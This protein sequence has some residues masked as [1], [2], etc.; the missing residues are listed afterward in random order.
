MPHLT[1]II[2]GGVFVMII[3]VTMIA[4]TIFRG[5]E[6]AH[7]ESLVDSANLSQT[8]ADNFNGMIREIDLGLLTI[9]DEANR[10]KKQSQ[11]DSEEIKLS[12]AKQ[13]ERHPGSLC[14]RI[15]GADGKL[16]VGLKNIDDNNA[17]ISNRESF[18]ILRDSPEIGLL[19][20]PPA[21]GVA[22]H[23]WLIALARRITNPD[24][25]FGG[26]VF[27]PISIKSLVGGF[28]KIDLGPNGAVALYHDSFR[29]TARY[30]EPVG[31]NNPIG[32]VL[33]S[34]QL[35]AIIS[36]KASI[37]HY[38]YSSSVDGVRRTATVR[39]VNGQQYYILVAQ[40]ED[41]YL[42][43]WRRKSCDFILFGAM[44]IVFLLVSMFV[45]FKRLNDW[46]SAISN[47]SE[48]EKKLRSLFDLSPMGIARN[49]LDGR[50]VDFNE[51][52]RKITG[53]DE[54]EL[55]EL[56]YYKLTPEEYLSDEYEHIDSL[57]LTGS[58][59][60]FEKEYR[61]KDN[62]IIPVQLRGILVNGSDGI[63][64]I[65]S[66]V[67]D[68]SGQKRAQEETLLAASVFHV[69]AEA[70]M[71]TDHTA[72]IISVNPAFTEITGFLE[73][74]V[75]GKTPR[76]MKS[77]R[78]E[79]SFYK[80]MWNALLTQGGWRGQIWNRRKDGEAFLAWQTISTVRDNDGKPIRYVS[81]FS[82]ITEL[83]HKD[84]HIRHQAYHDA[85]TGLPNR[86]LL[87]DRITHAIDIAKRG[88]QQVAVMFIDLDRFKIV[89]DSLGHD[90]GD[91]L[92]IQVAERITDCVRKSDTIAR[93]GGDEFV[94]VINDFTNV[95][96]VAAVADKICKQVVEA[97]F[98]QDHEI[99]IGASI[100]IALFPHDGDDVVAL[101]K[102]ADLAM[103]RAK[104]AGRNTVR[105]FDT[106]I[107]GATSGRLGL[108]LAL[109]NALKS[110]EFQLFYQPKIDLVSGRVN[111]AEALIRWNCPERGLVPPNVFIPLAEET[112]LIVAIG[113]WVLEEACRQLTEWSH[114]DGPSIR[115]S[116]NVS[117][118]QFNEH[119]FA[120]NIT[121]RLAHHQLSPSLLEIELTES[122]VMFNPSR[123]IAQLAQLQSLGVSVSVDDFGTGYS[124]L[125]YLKQ[126]P[127]NTLKIDRAFIH[128]VDTDLENA[129]I[130]RA[131]LSL[132]AALGLSVVAEGI[133]TLEEEQHL[134]DANCGSVQGFKYA[135]PLPADQFSAW[136][137]A[138]N[139]T[140]NKAP[141]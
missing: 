31:P 73:S 127:L 126:L 3:V 129:A 17:D 48:N 92:L 32:T 98:I 47:L 29:L 90:I 66:L 114:N 72:R 57:L 116:I 77:N 101:T 49:T 24:G 68:T 7:H 19:I 110:E 60:P 23:Q 30:P 103:Y 25:S 79:P 140:V 118:R 131:I 36:S 18:K 136:I 64:Y 123:T 130:V 22:T 125:A 135:K 76:V 54:A 88:Q 62:S 86:L 40:A 134:R 37:A 12:V 138:N 93:I 115:V 141:V 16:I 85:L 43:Q 8:L 91:L 104:E 11:W 56:D 39:K 26:A 61:R 81:V 4:V 102:N 34:D 89:N 105:F 107:D 14:Y 55:R 71:I 120:D 122:A 117:A 96:E 10:E 94:V 74:E 9:L 1:A 139:G 113:N 28:S 75:V 45:L 44:L 65:W 46:Q 58:Y 41:Y 121:Q 78:Q 124:C 80:A 63:P 100:G 111:G 21:F 137:S 38:D 42:E 52:F 20:M 59:G 70:I 84:E 99:H 69:A 128:K 119:D 87:Q 133:E 35:R 112:G 83:H 97:F 82:D 5:Y 67:E 108:E 2:G 33:I 95:A 106:E 109:R 51:A 15:Y 27:C 13:D 6:E 53:Y 132:S 50:F